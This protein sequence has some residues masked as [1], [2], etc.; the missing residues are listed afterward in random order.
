MDK[1]KK[2]AILVLC[3]VVLIGGASLIYNKLAKNQEGTGVGNNLIVTTS[4]APQLTEGDSV[5]V[6]KDENT[7][8]DS[9][10]KEEKDE[11]QK[12]ENNSSK[13]TSN[14]KE[15]PK[16]QSSE[17]ESKPTS[18]SKPAESNPTSSSK[19][20]ESKEETTQSSKVETPSQPESVESKPQRTEPKAA[21]FTVYDANGKAVKLSDYFG[22]PIVLNFWASWCGPCQ[23]E[24]P[25]FN[26]KYL[27][28][29][30]K[31][32]FLMVNLTT[33]SETVSKVQ[34][35]IADRGYSFPVLFDTTYSAA[36]AYAVYSIPATF[37]IDSEGYIMAHAKGSI[38][39]NTLQSGIDM[40][41]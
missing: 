24:M 35:F 16:P 8:S 39:S 25:D 21:D 9:Q 30:D 36:D 28:V 29:G 14:D 37:F 15:K 40:I 10:K 34:K 11:S 7:Q 18:S 26:Q 12:S 5:K 6:E 20:A 32:Q 19:P 23:R 31:V 41:K 38:D 13:P 3:F 27:E 1:K 33:G 2:L 22:K 17:T 4:S